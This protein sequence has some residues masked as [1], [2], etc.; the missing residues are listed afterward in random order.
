M[1]AADAWIDLAL[2][3]RAFPDVTPI[4]EIPLA[5]AIARQTVAVQ[6]RG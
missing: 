4:D 5:A 3:A 1:P 2:V 6:G